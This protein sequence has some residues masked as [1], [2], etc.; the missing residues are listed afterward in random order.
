MKILMGHERE[1]RMS[2]FTRKRIGKVLC[3]R[4]GDNE[5]LH[6]GTNHRQEEW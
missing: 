5:L 6:Q 3:L 4:F 2:V 1:R